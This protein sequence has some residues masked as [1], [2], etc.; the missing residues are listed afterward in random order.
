MNNVVRISDYARYEIL[1]TKH[2]LVVSLGLLVNNVVRIPDYARYEILYTKHWL[3]AFL[4]LA[5][6]QCGKDT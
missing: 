3:V 4:R 1:Y 5:S 6:E 2:W